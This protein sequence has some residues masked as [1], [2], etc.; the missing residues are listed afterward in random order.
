MFEDH[1]LKLLL[2]QLYRKLGNFMKNK[3]CRLAESQDWLTKFQFTPTMYVINFVK[4]QIMST[5]FYISGRSSSKS[6]L[7]TT[8]EYGIDFCRDSSFLSG[9]ML[10]VCSTEQDHV[11]VYP[12]PLALGHRIRLV[13]PRE[14]I[15]IIHRDTVNR[16]IWTGNT[17]N[18]F[19]I[20]TKTPYSAGIQPM[21][22]II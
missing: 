15:S 8:E 3:R 2:C 18:F 4:K 1:I 21:F 13:N 22:Q 12:K 10:H 9:S 7:S 14:S 16:T 17:I 6:R 11:V 5:H 20:I 19:I